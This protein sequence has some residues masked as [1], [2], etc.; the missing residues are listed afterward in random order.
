MKKYKNILILLGEFL[1][2]IIIYLLI[3]T[4]FATFNLI[5]YKTVSILS[6]IFMI[7][8]FAFT[9]FKIGKRSEKRGYLSGL[10]IG[11]INIILILIL[12]LLFRSFPS[13]KSLIYFSILLLSSTLGGMFGINKKKDM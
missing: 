13:L 6:L 4:L 2:A 1:S 11:L 5:S 10:I 7:L 12:A 8:L 9:G 3:I